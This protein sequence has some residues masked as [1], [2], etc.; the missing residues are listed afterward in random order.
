MAENKVS[1]ELLEDIVEALRGIV[2]EPEDKAEHVSLVPLAGGHGIHALTEGPGHHKVRGVCE[3]EVPS[4]Q[5]YVTI[6]TIGCIGGSFSTYVLKRVEPRKLEF[7]E[8]H[9]HRTTYF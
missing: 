1:M 8:K 4:G 6:N 7:A 9:V 5:V 3:Y 2:Y